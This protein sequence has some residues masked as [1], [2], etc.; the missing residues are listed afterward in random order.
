[1]KSF[2]SASPAQMNAGQWAILLAVALGII[3]VVPRVLEAAT[4]TTKA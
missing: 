3:Y 2:W 4:P 1:M